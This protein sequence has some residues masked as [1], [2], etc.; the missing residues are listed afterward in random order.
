[1]VISG[2][3]RRQQLEGLLSTKS[4]KEGL[5]QSRLKEVREYF[6]AYG[7]MPEGFRE[8]RPPRISDEVVVDVLGHPLSYPY[9]LVAI[10][11]TIWSSRLRSKSIASVAADAGWTFE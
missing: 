8:H 2:W 10:C 1:M 5:S 6:G 4:L 9:E 11:E 7:M 3:A